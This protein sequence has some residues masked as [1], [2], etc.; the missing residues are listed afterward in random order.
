M[1]ARIDRRHIGHVLPSFTA[2][3]EA[4][5]LRFFAKATGQRDPVYVDEAA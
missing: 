3:V 5:R 1:A 2:A 4:G